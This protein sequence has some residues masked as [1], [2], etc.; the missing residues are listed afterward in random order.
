M[1]IPK[2]TFRLLEPLWVC[3]KLQE[4]TYSSAPVFNSLGTKKC[5]PNCF[6][7]FSTRALQ[8][9]RRCRLVWYSSPQRGHIGSSTCIHW[10]CLDKH[11]DAEP[12]ADK[13]CRGWA[14][15]WRWHQLLAGWGVMALVSQISCNTPRWLQIHA[16]YNQGQ[17]HYNTTKKQHTLQPHLC[18]DKLLNSWEV[19]SERSF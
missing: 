3:T 10:W 1:C 16:A 13:R 17:I 7:P 14:N 6:S 5:F 12:R 2:L 19:S 18:G 15:D 9:P 4:R 11:G 8:L